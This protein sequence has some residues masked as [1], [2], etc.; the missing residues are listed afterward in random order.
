MKHVAHEIVF[1]AD[2]VIDRSLHTSISSS[3]RPNKDQKILWLRDLGG[4][5]AGKLLESRLAKHR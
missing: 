3:R 2:K 5:H 1:L 4:N